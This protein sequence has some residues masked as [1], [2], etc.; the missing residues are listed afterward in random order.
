MDARFQA[1]GKT[2]AKFNFCGQI[3]MGSPPQFFSL[4]NAIGESLGKVYFTHIFA[5]NHILHIFYHKLDLM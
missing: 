3:E 2:C 5:Q 1:S 4:E